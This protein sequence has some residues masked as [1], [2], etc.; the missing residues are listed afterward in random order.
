MGQQLLRADLGSRHWVYHHAG[1]PAR[2]PP[3]H[4]QVPRLPVAAG[5]RLPLRHGARL[6]QPAEGGAH[7]PDALKAASKLRAPGRLGADHRLPSYDTSGDGF[8]QS[9]ELRFAWQAATGEAMTE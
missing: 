8:L 9:G 1:D 4:T 6:F 3:G 2:L 7:A 5:A